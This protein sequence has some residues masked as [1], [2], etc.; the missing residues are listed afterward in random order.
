MSTWIGKTFGPLVGR[1]LH[2]PHDATRRLLLGSAAAVL[3]ASGLS[4]SP[5]AAAASDDEDWLGTWATSPQTQNA[6]QTPRLFPAGTTIRQIV[7]ISHGGTELR[8]RVSNELGTEPLVIGRAAVALHQSGPMIVPGSSRPVT[9]GGRASVSVPAG[10]PMVSDPI[11]LAAAP[12]SDL[13]VSLYLPQAT[14]GRTWHNVAAQTNY[15]S[16][17]GGD[18]TSSVV[19]PVAASANNSWFLSGVSVRADDE[20]DAAVVT[21][22]DSITDGTRSTPNRNARWPNV[23]ALRLQESSALRHLSVLNEGISGN[24]LLS[25]GSGPNTLARLDRD[26]LAKPR[27]KYMTV[28]IGINDIGNAAR[29]TG[30]QVSAADI[31]SGYQQIIARAHARGIK[32]YGATLTPIQGSGYDFPAAEATRQQVNAWIRTSKAF[33]AVIDFDAVTRD[34]AQPARFLPE[35]DSGDHLHPNDAGYAAMGRAIPLS[36]FQ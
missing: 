18:Y 14:E 17:A 8:I 1:F 25:Q 24:R 12:L 6:T 26:V 4:L 16:H 34:P 22:G 31:I 28:L 15:I 27:V 30:P 23:L 11:P 9:F 10:A 7:R 19:M 35:Y 36:L 2:R 3:L 5:P 33:D 29:G 20:Q 13:A 32:V 21:L